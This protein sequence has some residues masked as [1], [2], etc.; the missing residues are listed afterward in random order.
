MK[1]RIR[2]YAAAAG[3][4]LAAVT[5]AHA[6]NYTAILTGTQEAPPNNAPGIGATVLKFDPDT[7]ILEINVAFSSLS[8]GTTAAHLHCCTDAPFKGVAGV[9]TEVPTLSGFPLGVTNG[10]YSNSYNTLLASTWNPAF[11]SRFGGSTAFAEA[12][13]ESGLNNGLAYFN[14]HTSAYPNGEI[15]GFYTPAL[16]VAAVPEPESIALLGIGLPA[17]LLLARRR[18]KNSIKQNN[19]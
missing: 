13:L 6:A 16:V 9:A 19:V 2:N 18:S 10:A 5:A 12:A 1:Q 15:R 4:L 8:S 11:L 17:M 3:L 7:H 14:I